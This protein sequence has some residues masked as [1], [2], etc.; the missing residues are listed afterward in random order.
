MIKVNGKE[1]P[2]NIGGIS[3]RKPW[4][5]Y[6]R[7]GAVKKAGGGEL[8]DVGDPLIGSGGEFSK[9][10][11][12]ANKAAD[13]G[14][15]VAYGQMTGMANMAMA[16][17][18][19][20]NSTEP[21]TT[22]QMIAPSADIALQALR[23]SGARPT[24][25]TSGV[26]VGPYGAHMLRAEERAAGAT[27]KPHPVY[28]DEVMQRAERLRPEFRD[29]FIGHQVDMRDAQ[30]RQALTSREAVGPQHSRDVF[31]TSGWSRGAEGTPRKEIPD[32]G[33]KLVP[34]KGTEKFVIEHPAGDFHK[35]Y[36]IPPVEFSSN[37]KGM[38]YLQ[39]GK[40]GKGEA[41][42]FPDSNRIIVGGTPTKTGLK[43]A[44]SPVLHELQHAI[45]KKEG[46]AFGSNPAATMHGREFQQEFYPRESHPEKATIYGPKIGA[47][48]EIPSWHEEMAGQQAKKYDPTSESAGMKRA[49]FEAYR[50]SA[51]ETEARNVQARR[52]KGYNYGIHPEDTEDITRGL[53]WVNKTEFADGGEVSQPP[54]FVRAEARSPSGMLRSSV[55][56]RTDKIPMKVGGGSYV[57]PADIPSALGQGNTMAGGSILDKMFNKGPYGMNLPRAKAGTSTK[58]ARMSSLTK[59]R[60]STG[61]ADGGDTNTDI[62][63]AG[64][65]YVLSPEQVADI[66]G[67]DMTAGHNILDQF[68]KSVRQQH[69]NTLKKL[70]GP[71]KD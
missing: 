48:A 33:A 20:Y 50:R 38:E 60:K 21:V 56:G 45:Q 28:G 27:P 13:I 63:A 1:V 43:E 15:K 53:Q 2:S 71:K 5:G 51:G 18:R 69:I 52:A 32:I 19:A 49:A 36:D 23:N 35:I 34:L 70:P 11:P 62:I 40:M 54:W 14:S 57:L 29:A 4:K 24:P 3:S 7:G 25:G 22:E 47:K 41:M 67:G 9:G 17:G 12:W 10:S 44:I 65:E 58:M 6:K 66:G 8:E 42:F 39:Y 31:P 26:F 55:P 30:A 68:V 46:L 59:T 64:G 16:P 61:F 37:L